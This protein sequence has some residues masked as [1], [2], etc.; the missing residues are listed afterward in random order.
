MTQEENKD[1]E[2]ILRSTF[3]CSENLQKETKTGT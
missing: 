2:H 1:T 3:I